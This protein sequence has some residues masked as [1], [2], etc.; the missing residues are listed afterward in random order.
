MYLN[1]THL[2][3]LREFVR[4]GT[5]SA[6][7]DALGYT[8]GAI[9]QQIAALEKSVG[10]PVLTKQGRH[11]MLT[12][13]GRVLAEHSHELLEAEE[14]ARAAVAAA[15]LEVSGQLTL[16]TWGSSVAALLP[17]VLDRAAQDF[18]NLIIRSR[19]VDVDDAARAVRQGQV[20]VA[21]GLDYPDWP[22][23]RDREIKPMRLIEERFAVAISTENPPLVL[24]DSASIRDL[25]DAPWIL[26]PPHTAMGRATRAALRRGGIEP[27]I[28]HEVADTAAAIALSSRGLGIAPVTDM[29]LQLAPE[30]KVR[31]VVLAERFVRQIVLFAPAN[32][33]GR[34]S[35]AAFV[36]TAESAVG[37]WGPRS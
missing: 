20:D 1:L 33:V 10:A 11:V 27:Q 17:Q 26:P 2:A 15:R 36:R 29:M 6:A 35:I 8:P 37:G 18:P 16:G 30:A 19:E 22:V 14:R 25:A 4:E 24:N 21:F 28:T 5:L 7:A 32:A 9:S 34:P 13:V 3:T 23:P 12:D 31:K